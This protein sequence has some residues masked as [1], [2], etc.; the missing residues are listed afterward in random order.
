MK[1]LLLLLLPLNVFADVLK[2]SAEELNPEAEEILINKP[3][4]YLRNQSMIYDF[5]SDLG[6]KDQRRYTGTD[7]NRF[8]MAGHLYGNYEQLGD[9]LGGEAVYMRKSTSYNEIWYGLQLFRHTTIFS[10]ITQN[11]TEGSDANAE[12]NFQRENTS[13]ATVT[14]LGAGVGYRFRFLADAINRD[15]IFE[16]VDV[17]LNAIQMNDSFI[18][19]TYQ[20]YGLTTN[21]GIHKRSSTRFFYGGK[22]SYNI[23]SVTRP[24]IGTESK[25][26]RSLTLG[27]LSLAF[28]LGFYY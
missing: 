10:A 9:L 2:P 21:Y 1:Y 25:S 3:E 23:A 18:D 13:E 17:F 11:H 22:I 5:N 20:G 6:I 8:S 4:K 7:K 16:T 28:E 14:G 15:D 26:D 12:V 19:E 24:A 27:W